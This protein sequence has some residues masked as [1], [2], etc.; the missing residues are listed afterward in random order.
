MHM[1][2]PE[3]RKKIASVQSDMK[4]IVRRYIYFLHFEKHSSLI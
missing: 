4:K 2:I 1:V 3:A